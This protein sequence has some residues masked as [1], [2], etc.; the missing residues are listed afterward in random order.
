MIPATRPRRLYWTLQV[1]GWLLYAAIGF[2]TNALFA[3]AGL[4]TALL[5]LSG[6]AILFLFTHGLRGLILRRGWLDRSIGQLALRVLGATF[7]LAL[8]S[9]LL[10]S[11]LLVWVFDLL[12]DQ[13][14]SFVVLGVYVFQT[15]VILLLWTL[16][17]VSVHYF[18]HYKREEIERWRLQS[19]A[20]EAELAALIAQLNP[21]F[22]FNCLN[23][24]RALVREDPEKAREMITRL[25]DFL[26]YSIQVHPTETVRLER[27]LEIV[28]DYLALEAI[29]LEDRLRVVRRIDPETLGQPVPVMAL[30]LLVENAIKHGINRLP[31]G[32]E[33]ALGA[34]RVGDLV[35]IEVVNSG[36]LAAPA[37]DDPDGAGIGLRNARERLELL[38]GPRAGLVLE[39][40][41]PDRVRAT[42]RLPV[43]PPCP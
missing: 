29:Q 20:R 35:E 22:V 10:I 23:N 34:R 1:G 37:E 3:R 8:V 16:I 15:Q 7:L 26:R 4:R 25:S 18:R 41:G 5:A 11:V 13:Q 30:Q 2:G 21:H 42:L 28:E 24:I 14:Y 39:P 38:F 36:Q 27:E 17:Y 40:D 9:Q 32:G 12:G 6:A 43:S 19:V 31:G 33:I